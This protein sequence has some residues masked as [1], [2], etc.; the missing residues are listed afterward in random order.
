M[1]ECIHKKT[2]W[3]IKE[4]PNRMG[5]FMLH[6]LSVIPGIK[7]SFNPEQL[8]FLSLYG[9]YCK[10]GSENKIPALFKGSCGLHDVKMAFYWDDDKSTMLHKLYKSKKMGWFKNVFKNVRGYLFVKLFNVDPNIAATLDQKPFYIH[11]GD[12][13]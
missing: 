3:K 11:P 2:V 1:P 9:L 6:I 8:S 13:S 10:P 12:L 4:L 5:L 7:K